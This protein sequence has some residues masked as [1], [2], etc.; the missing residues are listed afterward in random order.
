M[1]LIVTGAAGAFGRHVVAAAADAGH[2]VV[3]VDR[4]EGD[5]PDIAGVRYADVDLCDYEA[6]SAV[7]EGSDAIIHLAAFTR[8]SSRPEPE[9]HNNNVVASYNVLTA[10]GAAGVEKV[11][12]ASS[13]NAIGGLYSE[14]PRYDYFPVDEQ[15]PAYTEDPYSLS[16]LTGEIQAADFA[17]RHPRASVISLRIH[18]LM[19]DQEQYRTWAAMND[20]STGRDLWGYTAIG[21]ATAACLAAIATD[22]V[23]S[24]VLYVVAPTT[25]STR[26][27]LD[28]CREFHS[29]VPITCELA[30]REG[31][32]D[33]SRLTTVLGITPTSL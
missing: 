9:V 28:L 13:V 18:A 29:G 19:E 8:P 21:D 20:G 22:F 30:G 1:L 16:K 3:A 17:R 15:H 33:C 14:R 27:T 11:C 23:G 7:V 12:L 24:T 31:L 10:A 32:F 6:V 2:Q 25:S 26:P 5:P 4:S